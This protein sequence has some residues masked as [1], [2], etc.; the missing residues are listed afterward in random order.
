MTTPIPPGAWTSPATQR[1]RGPILDVLRP[2]MPAVGGVLEIAAGAGEHS[3]FL[4]KAMPGLAWQPTDGEPTALTSIAAWREAAGLANLLPPKLLDVTEPDDWPVEPFDAIV[5]INMVHISPWMATEGLM[6]GAEQV[7][8]AG[9]L[10]Y[11][12]GPYREADRPIAA[13]NEAFDENLKA[14]DPSWGLRRLE[15]VKALAARHSLELDERIE[16]PANNLSVVF[17]RA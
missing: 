4:A 6:A 13:S 12:Y 3:V 5:C 8:M 10:L 14:R 1:N 15:D 9:G 7:L 2:R 11:L 17:R 16:M